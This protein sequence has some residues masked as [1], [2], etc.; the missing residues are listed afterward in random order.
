VTAKIDGHWGR[1]SDW[2]KCDAQCDEGKR[3]RMRMCDNP[4]P[5]HGGKY[6]PGGSKEEDVCKTRRC[7]LGKELPDLFTPQ[8]GNN[9]CTHV[10]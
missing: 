10:S 5:K 2:T 3:K 6:C 4:E 1:W 9:I 8:H 7:H